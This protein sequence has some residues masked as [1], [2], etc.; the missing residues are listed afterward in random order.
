MSNPFDGP[1]AC[2]CIGPPGDCPCIRLSRCK[3][4]IRP[5]SSKQAA[6]EAVDR[7]F[8]P[9]FSK[10]KNK[11]VK[12]MKLTKE[13]AEW[14]Q[15]VFDKET[16]GIRELAP[17][18]I[19]VI[20]HKIT[21]KEFPELHMRPKH[22]DDDEELKIYE[23]DCDNADQKCIVVFSHE[24]YTHMDRKQFREFA[25]KVNKIVGYLDESENS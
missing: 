22:A 18:D 15:S 4:D 19:R 16:A 9:G 23:T 11:D 8:G 17:Y 2:Y 12:P 5:I 24:E 20:L 6:K 13:Q 21:E 14:L 1:W 25:H 10:L 3:P 7:I